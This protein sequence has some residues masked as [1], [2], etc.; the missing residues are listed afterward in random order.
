MKLVFSSWEVEKVEK[1]TSG[2][3]SPDNFQTS[4]WDAERNGSD[5]KW[6]VQFSQL[7]SLFTS[8]LTLLYSVFNK[9]KLVVQKAEISVWS[10]G[11]LQNWP[12]PEGLC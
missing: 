9:V 5:M 12:Q 11:V 3:K 4:H 8:P 7:L 10:E 1:L 2:A 6:Q